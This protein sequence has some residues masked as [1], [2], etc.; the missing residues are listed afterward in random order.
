[1]S[2]GA[3]E[4]IATLAHDLRTPLAIVSGFTEML[5]TRYESLTD[6]QRR[7]F[8]ERAHTAADEMKAI[9]DAERSERLGF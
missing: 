6:E 5:L 2:G 7:E 1:M 4:R 3:D 9:L 8:L